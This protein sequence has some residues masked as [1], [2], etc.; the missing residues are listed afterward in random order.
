MIDKGGGVLKKTVSIGNHIII[1]TNTIFI[2]QN[3]PNGFENRAVLIAL[4]QA[5]GHCIEVG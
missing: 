5:V 1:K 2:K 4:S 3:S